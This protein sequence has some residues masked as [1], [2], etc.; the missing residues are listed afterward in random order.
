MTYKFEDTVPGLTFVTIEPLDDQLPPGQGMFN[1]YVYNKT[2]IT[3][4][5]SLILRSNYQVLFTCD[6][7]SINQRSSKEVETAIINLRPGDRKKL[8]CSWY[9]P[10]GSSERMIEIT[11]TFKTTTSESCIFT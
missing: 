2:K 11:A 1:V 6:G 9:D 4:I 5:H 10:T 7:K 8:L 3:Q